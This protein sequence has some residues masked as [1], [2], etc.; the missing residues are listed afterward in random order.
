MPWCIYTT[1]LL[2]KA[3]S[4][5]SL[6]PEMSP[7]APCPGRT[8]EGHRH[9]GKPCGQP[10]HS[11]RSRRHEPRPPLGEHAA[12][13]SVVRAEKLPDAG[14]DHDAVVGPWEISHGPP[15]AAVDAT[16]QQM[17]DGTVHADLR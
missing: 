4:I 6:R 11:P 1:A 3:Q 17:A 12:H 7:A 14:L 10:R 16:S 15:I 9:V 8:A 5:R 13:T 2:L